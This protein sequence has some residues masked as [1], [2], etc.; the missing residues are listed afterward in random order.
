MMIRQDGVCALQMCKPPSHTLN[1]HHLLC[2]HVLHEDSSVFHSASWFFLCMFIFHA[3]EIESK[4]ENSQSK[5][6]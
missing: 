3:A 4:R 1:L 6:D 2:Q 5:V